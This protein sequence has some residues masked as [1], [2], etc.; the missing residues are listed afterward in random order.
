MDRAGYGEFD[1]PDGRYARIH[2]QTRFLHRAAQLVPELKPSL[3]EAIDTLPSDTFGRLRVP[4]YLPGIDEVD[5][6]NEVARWFDKSV[7]QL[8]AV[9]TAI[10]PWQERW[11]LADEWAGVQVSAGLVQVPLLSGDG[12]V[13]SAVER[14]NLAWLI[15]GLRGNDSPVYPP[16]KAEWA[17]EYFLSLVEPQPVDFPFSA[18]WYPQ[19]EYRSDIIRWLKDRFE[20]ELNAYLDA[21]EVKMEASGLVRTKKK[22]FPPWRGPDAAL[23]LAHSVSATGVHPRGSCGGTRR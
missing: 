18:R 3:A 21:T 7:T 16:E 15:F 12:R 11:R 5:H 14:V 17:T 20:N 23:R 1:T 2:L 6:D 4:M 22:T 8:D 10:R 9:S 13:R 19:L